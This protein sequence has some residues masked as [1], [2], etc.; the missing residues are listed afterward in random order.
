MAWYTLSK[1]RWHF[2][3]REFKARIAMDIFYIYKK[4]TDERILN[5]TDKIIVYLSHLYFYMWS[6][7]FN[8]LPASNVFVP[9]ANLCKQ[10]RPRSGPTKHRAWSG[11]KLT[12]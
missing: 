4:D 7:D 9:F 2:S 11:F 10:F 12:L 8:P 3:L 1:Q 5:L 6:L